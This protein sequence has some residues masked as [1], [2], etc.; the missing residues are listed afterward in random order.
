[1]K[2]FNLPWWRIQFYLSP[3]SRG[4]LVTYYYPILKH[5]QGC[6]SMTMT[7]KCMHRFKLPGGQKF[8]FPVLASKHFNRNNFEFTDPLPLCFIAWHQHRFAR[9]GTGTFGRIAP[10]RGALRQGV[11]FQYTKKDDARGMR[12]EVGSGD[13]VLRLLWWLAILQ[14]HTNTINLIA[15]L[16][17]LTIIY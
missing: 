13:R 9:P 15:D 8:I 12:K 10:L 2:S 5:N 17:G 3:F 1:M 6:N 4:H 14:I 16:A 11:I 7:L